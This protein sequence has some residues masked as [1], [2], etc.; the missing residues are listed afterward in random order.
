MQDTIEAAARDFLAAKQEEHRAWL[1]RLA[2]EERIVRLVGA[3]EDGTTT[4]RSADLVIKTVG[5]IN[6][7]LDEA[8][9]HAIAPSIPDAIRTR[10][11]K[12]KPEPVIREV[13][14]LRDN[15]P[16]L[17]AMLSQALTMKPAKTAVSVELA[18]AKA[19]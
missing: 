5:K 11:V 13:K 12:L 8:A 16:Q 10:L 14:F 9:W 15:E 17:F 7:A 19:A 2:A 6:Y 3:K 4:A 18:V 1:A